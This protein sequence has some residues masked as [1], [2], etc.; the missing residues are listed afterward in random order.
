T[1]GSAIVIGMLGPALLGI[2]LP[3]ACKDYEEKQGGGSKEMGG[4][5]SAWH[6][7]EMRAFRVQP[8]GKA[9]GLRVV[10]VEALCPGAR[11]FVQRVRRNAT[12]VEANADMVLR[13]NDIVA[14][15][16]KREVLVGLIGQGAQE[17]E[18]PEL[19]NVPVE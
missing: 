17:I 16:G 14:V 5:G 7:W 11:I 9:N 2:N 4:A 13:E 18:D 10:E 12:I 6:R 1:V 19:L 8:E 15:T 3:A